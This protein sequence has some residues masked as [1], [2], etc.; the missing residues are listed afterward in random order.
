MNL[1]GFVLN[2][3]SNLLMIFIK[4]AKPKEHKKMRYLWINVLPKLSFSYSIN[5]DLEYHLEIE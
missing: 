2:M 3:Q 1:K 4:N 5:E